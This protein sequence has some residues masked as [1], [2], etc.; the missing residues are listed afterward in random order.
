MGI[1][2]KL[3]HLLHVYLP[4]IHIFFQ[5]AM[6]FI[7]TNRIKGD[8]LEFGVYGGNTFTSAYYFAKLYKLKMR[9]YAFDSFNGLPEVDDKHFNTGMCCMSEK[10]FK[11]VIRKRGVNLNDVSIIPGWY[12]EVL[13]KQ[14]K[15]KLKI[16][17]ASFIYIDCDLYESTKPVLEF[18][19]DY[20]QNGT[21]LVFDD[22]NLYNADPN[23]GERRAFKEWLGKHK[24]IT[25]EKYLSIG[26]MGQSFILRNK[27][28]RGI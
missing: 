8:Y 22:W 15:S 23:Q 4:E 28:N 5:K 24:N 1:K 10:K 2:H 20:I 6:N 14:T 13:N 21:I 26:Y 18:I 19:T 27:Y 7:S 12:D 16:K 11:K 25:A 3:I 17:K 9:F